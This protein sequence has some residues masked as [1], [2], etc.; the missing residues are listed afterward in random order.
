MIIHGRTFN[1]GDIVTLDG[2]T[3]EV[4]AGE[5]KVIDPELSG[6]FDELM[7]IADKYRTLGVRTNAETPHDATVAKKF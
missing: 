3:G 2:A 5:L 4:F 6:D 7:K 1:E